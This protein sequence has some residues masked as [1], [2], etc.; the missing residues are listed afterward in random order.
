LLPEYVA[1]IEWSWD[2]VPSE[3]LRALREL[4]AVAVER[5]PWHRERL[6]GLDFSQLSEA[7]VESLP[8]MT[9]ADLMDNFD[10]IVTD[11]RIS[12]ALCEAHLEDDTGAAYLFDHYSVVA[13]GGSSGPT[14]RV[15][16]RLGC[17][18]DLLRVDRALPRAR[19]GI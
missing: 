11:R 6:V 7:D 8:V 9:K 17:L 5:S 14:G 15:R 3:R 18:G 12:R 2:Q 13:S 10:E 1:R 19:L 16:L 4:L